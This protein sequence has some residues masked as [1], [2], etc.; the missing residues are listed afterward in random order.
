M[1]GCLKIR[2]SASCIHAMRISPSLVI[3]EQTLNTSLIGM[4][5]PVMKG[6]TFFLLI[7]KVTESP[8]FITSENPVISLA[9]MHVS[10]PLQV[11]SLF[12]VSEQ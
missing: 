5:G 7:N 1:K 9:H 10:T 4:K 12:R 8:C 3:V 6:Q 2:A 11:R